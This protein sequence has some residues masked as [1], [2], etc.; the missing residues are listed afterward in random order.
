MDSSFYL[1]IIILLI[2]I[3][4]SV[5]ILREDERFVIFRLG[6]FFKVVGP[7]L[8]L[9]LPLIDRGMRVNLNRD[10]PGWQGL[11]KTELDEKINTFVLNKFPV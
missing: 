4:T 6:R 1:S 3:F 8:V 9:I 11:S 10:F 2:I 5:K 7:G